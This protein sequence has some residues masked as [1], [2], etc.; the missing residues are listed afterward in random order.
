MKPFAV[1]IDD[2]LARFAEAV[3]KALCAR[4]PNIKPVSQWN[5]FLWSDINDVPYDD[6]V[7]VMIED[8][9][10]TECVPVPGAVLAMQKIRASGATIVLITARGYHPM[11]YELTHAWLTHHGIPFDDLIIV[12]KGQTKA[13]AAVGKYP[14]GFLY[15]IDDNADNLD[16]MRDAGLLS[17]PILIDQPW[18]QDRKDFKIGASRFKTISDFVFSLEY[19]AGRENRAPLERNFSAVY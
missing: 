18:N 6:F 2:V 9:L 13:Q 5:T 14:K 7:R 11:G 17:N 19:A 4:Y 12:P 3:H 16:H 8:K 10:L 15:M 1:D